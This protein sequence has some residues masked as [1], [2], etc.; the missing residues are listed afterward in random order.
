MKTM[1]AWGLKRASNNQVE[2]WA[3][4]QGLKLLRK[5]RETVITMIGDWLITIKQ[6]WTKNKDGRSVESPIMN[7]ISL[8]EPV[9]ED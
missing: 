2:F 8:N 9:W 4:W 3:F 5:K 6:I 7:R 1:F